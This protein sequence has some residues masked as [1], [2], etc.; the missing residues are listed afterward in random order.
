M[1]SSSFRQAAIWGFSLKFPAKILS[2]CHRPLYSDQGSFL[3]D[4]LGCFWRRCFAAYVSSYVRRL[5]WF[6]V[7]VKGC[8]KICTKSNLTILVPPWHLNKPVH[9]DKCSFLKILNHFK[10]FFVWHIGTCLNRKWKVNYGNGPT[11]GTVSEFFAW[12]KLKTIFVMKK[13]F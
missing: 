6:K 5:L 9:L 1:Y 7:I 8:Q 4:Y 2:F 13:N 11:I 12:I 3:I 10:A